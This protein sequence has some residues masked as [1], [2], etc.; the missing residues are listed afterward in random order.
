MRF[1]IAILLAASAFGQTTAGTKVTFGAKTT[2]IKG[3]PPTLAI[4]SQMPL[5]AGVSN[6]TSP[7]TYSFTN[8][9]GTYLLVGVSSANCGPVAISTV[10]YGGSSMTL[11]KSVDSQINGARISIYELKTPLTG[12][13]N[14]VITLA[15]SAAIVSG[16]ISFK[17]NDPTTPAR[18]SF[19]NNAASGNATVNA[20]STLSGNI[21]VDMVGVG[22]A[23]TASAQTNSWIKNVNGSICG[24]NGAMSWAAGNGGTVTMNY[25]N[26][27]DQWGIVAVEVA[28]Q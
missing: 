26:T 7:F 6:A 11:V 10:T 24:N 4:D 19:S 28:T 22:S 17:Y 5:S 3:A 8:A 1:L 21:V 23:I 12:A 16:A 15:S 9:A 14:V 2:L 13:N 25:T 20:T 27:S 18:A